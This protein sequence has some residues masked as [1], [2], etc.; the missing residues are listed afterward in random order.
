MATVVALALDALK[1][2]GAPVTDEPR[3][4]LVTLPLGRHEEIFRQVEEHFSALDHMSDNAHVALDAFAATLD[5]RQRIADL[6]QRPPTDLYPLL[7]AMAALGEASARLTA[8]RGGY[9]AAAASHQRMTRQGSKNLEKRRADQR[10]WWQAA[11]AKWADIS[12]ETPNLSAKQRENLVI[13]HLVE[14]A[15]GRPVPKPSA[16]K[17]VRLKGWRS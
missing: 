5:V 7:M 6:E 8:Q 17:R 2:E 11:K 10:W 9:F 15:D 4:R 16:V 12:A 14:I 3:A 13:A 1:H